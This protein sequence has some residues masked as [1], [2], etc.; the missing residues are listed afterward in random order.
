MLLNKGSFENLKADRSKAVILAVILVYF[1]LSVVCTRC[2]YRIQYSIVS[3]LYLSCCGLITSVLEERAHLSASFTC[4]DFIL[5]GFCSERFS[6]GM[7]CFISL[8]HSLCLP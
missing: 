1:L 3:H 5:C 7:A 2:F 8:W 6:L 4:N